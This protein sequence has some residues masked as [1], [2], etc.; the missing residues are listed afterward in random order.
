MN[1]IDL[2]MPYDEAENYL[3]PSNREKLNNVRC[4]YDLLYRKGPKI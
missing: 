3:K 4:K 2:E 1:Y